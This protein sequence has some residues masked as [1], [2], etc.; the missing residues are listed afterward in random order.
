M[1]KLEILKKDQ[2]F[3]L[4]F[5][6]NKIKKTF[7]FLK[8]YN[9]FKT[10]KYLKTKIKK[11]IIHNKIFLTP[12]FFSFFKKKVASKKDDKNQSILER[13]LKKKKFL[14]KKYF[15]SLIKIQ[16]FNKKN[17]FNL[18]FKFI[19]FIFKKGKKFFWEKMFS[20]IFNNL[21]LKYKYSRSFILAKIFVRLYT[22]VELRKIKSRKRLSFIPFF[23][24]IKR[25]L[26]LALKWIF[27]SILNNNTLTSSANK[28]FIELSQILSLKSCLSIKKLEE[29]NIASFENRSN[30]Y[31]KWD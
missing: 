23:I 31:Y 22:R 5:F 10:N 8:F 30:I 11:R 7:Y 13:Y 19:N 4:D 3:S 12:S 28:F 2:K 14:K 24:K 16:I 27:L 17:S 9:K 21:S 20:N 15:K 29:N 1:T 18:Y 6:L 26:F 25:S